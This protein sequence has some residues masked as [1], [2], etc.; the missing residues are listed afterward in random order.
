MYR[1]IDMAAVNQSSDHPR[2]NVFQSILKSRPP[3]SNYSRA[4]SNF[5]VLIPRVADA[6]TTEDRLVNSLNA[7]VSSYNNVIVTFFFPVPNRN[8]FSRIVYFDDH[9]VEYLDDQ[10]REQVYVHSTGLPLSNPTRSQSNSP[11]PLSNPLHSQ[12]NPPRFQSNLHV[13]VFCTDDKEPSCTSAGI[14]TTHTILTPTSSNTH[15]LYLFS[16]LTHTLELLSDLT[17][18]TPI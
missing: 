12:S 7:Y 16:E 5:P 3:Q 4:Q 2:P 14:E 11:P 15:H 1:E 13:S 8:R 18:F 6:I 10:G 9:V 17:N